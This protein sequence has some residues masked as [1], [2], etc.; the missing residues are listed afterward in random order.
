M[1][2][3]GAKN[4]CLSA[5]SR[6]DEGDTLHIGDIELKVIHT[7]GHTNRRKLFICPRA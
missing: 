5:D 2:F 6:V 7:P 1:G 4:T 3:V